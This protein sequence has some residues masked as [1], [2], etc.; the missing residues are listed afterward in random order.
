MKLRLLIVTCLVAWTAGCI[1]YPRTHV[2]V[3]PIAVAGVHSFAPAKTAPA[4]YPD[5]RAK[6]LNEPDKD[7]R[8][9]ANR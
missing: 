6:E 3:T 7:D 2:L 1:N 4:K 5:L 9:M 8:P